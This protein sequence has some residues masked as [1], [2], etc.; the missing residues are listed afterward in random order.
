MA[1]GWDSLDPTYNE[2]TPGSVAPSAGGSVA[3]FS[4]GSGKRQVTP[5]G[6]NSP[7]SPGGG[8]GSSSAPAGNFLIGM[9]VFFVFLLVIMF[10]AHRFGD[11]E[12][13]SNLKAS[14]Y[15]VLF[16]AFVAIAG[17]PVIKIGV[18]Q[19]ASMD[20]PLADHASAWVTAV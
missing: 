1:A 13:F 20:V 10:V 16:I 5:T 3:L 17:I 7:A 15:N 18:V 12:N 4:T 14:A 6:S 19:L 9:L 2:A 8:A 11:S